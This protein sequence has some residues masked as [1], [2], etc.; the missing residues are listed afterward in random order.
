M[1]VCPIGPATLDHPASPPPLDESARAEVIAAYDIAGARTF[2]ALDD[3]VAFAAELCG[4]PTALV[5]L[6]EEAHQR[7]LSRVGLDAE[8]TPRSMSF[9]AHAMRGE[10][11]MEVPD[12]TADSRFADNPLVTGAPSIRFYAGAPLVSREGVP[13][14]ALCVISPEAR[15]GGLSAF[16]RRGLEILASAVMGRLDDRRA[17]R[18][19]REAEAENRAALAQSDLRFRTLADTMPQMVWS[20]RPD[21]YHDYYNARWYEFT[22]VPAGT[23]DGEGWNDVFHPDDQARAWTVWRH[24]LSTGDPYQIEY[25][26]KHFDGTYRWVLG[27]ALPIRDEAGAITRWFGTCTDIH[28][29]KLALEEREI[30]S[31]E[32]SH[33]I[34][35]IFAV[36]SGLI[37]FAS[38]TYPDFAPIS[39]DLRARITALGRAHDFVRPH[40]AQ[41]RPSSQQDSLRGMLGEL[42]LPYQLSSGERIRIEG[43]DVPIDDR[44]ATPIAL[45]FHELAT[46]ASK[47][48]AL[49]VEHGQVTLSLARED[50]RVAIRWREC[51]GPIVQEP[52]GSAGFGTQLIELSAVRQ[53][54]GTIARTWAPEGLEVCLLLPLASLS[55]P[56]MPART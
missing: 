17:A 26:L 5:S 35:N 56:A 2:G 37:A 25:R 50:N 47:Y 40:S 31:Q 51:G 55:R 52:Q 8:S 32:L 23:T 34:K 11:V 41:S 6:V 28:E 3:I 19:A 13:L 48:G 29:Q 24:S 42:F 49:S 10:K 20:T 14:G 22:G 9:C 33:R 7:F 15:P 53:L 12:A 18:E 27:R 1:P 38:R 4:T 43:P 46:N 39:S 30:I 54:G 36:I 21:G 44:S 45:L 16:Q